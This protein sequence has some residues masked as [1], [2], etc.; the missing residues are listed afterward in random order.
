MRAELA[1]QS[2]KSDNHLGVRC[3]ATDVTRI[4]FVSPAFSCAARLAALLRGDGG[5]LQ[6]TS[7]L[8]TAPRWSP[9]DIFWP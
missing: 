1:N 8:R 6:R 7:R 4:A 9:I 5:D 2:G 3:K